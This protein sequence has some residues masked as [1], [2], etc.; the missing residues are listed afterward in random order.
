MYMYM[1]VYIN[2]YYN[3]GYAYTMQGGVYTHIASLGNDRVAS[4]T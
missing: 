1:Y 4:I 2:V 3:N